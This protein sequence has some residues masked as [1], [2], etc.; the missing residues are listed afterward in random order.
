MWREPR[1]RVGVAPGIGL[2]RPES[3]RCSYP[4]DVSRTLIRAVRLARDRS[5][6]RPRQ[7]RH[8]AEVARARCAA[9][10]WRISR[11]ACGLDR[12]SHARPRV[13]LLC[14]AGERAAAA[15]QARG[16]EWLAHTADDRARSLRPARSSARGP[17]SEEC[18]WALAG[19][20]RARQRAERLR[21]TRLAVCAVD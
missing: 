15:S 3:S 14:A 6:W 1:R 20:D 7:P 12:R 13:G 17:C 21:A 18:A 2:N 11:Y 4:E 8:H 19:R 5:L 16:K 10:G 9:L